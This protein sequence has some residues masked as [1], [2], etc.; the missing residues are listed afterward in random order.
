[1]ATSGHPALMNFI[2][3][4]PACK[5]QLPPLPVTNILPP[6]KI[7]CKNKQSHSA[8]IVQLQWRHADAMLPIIIASPSKTGRCPAHSCTLTGL[9]QDETH[10]S[11]E[12]P[13]GH[14]L[15]SWE[16]RP[17][18]N[19][20][21]FSTATDPQAVPVHGVVVMHHMVSMDAPGCYPYT[22]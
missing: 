10:D 9:P 11:P 3:G 5:R 1:M 20:Q 15:C 12:T 17:A 19:R 21:A 22:S 2:N 13:K 18:T 7:N 4:S 16:D 8:E 6:A 14:M